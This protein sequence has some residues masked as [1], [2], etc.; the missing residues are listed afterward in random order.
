M[1]R[2]SAAMLMVALV[3][4]CGNQQASQTI[5]VKG[6]DTELN[7]VQSFAEHY[8][9]SHPSAMVSVL[10]GG[11]GTGIAALINGEVDIANS[12]RPMKDKEKEDARARGVE[13]TEFVVASDAIA[14]I[15]SN[16]NQVSDISGENLGKLFRGEVR[17]WKE[18]G[19]PD[20]PV[21]LYGRQSNSGTYVF[22]QEEAL[23]GDYSADMKQMNGNAQIVE[24]I[25]S[26]RAGIGYVGLGYVMKDGKFTTDVKVLK[27]D[28][29]LPGEDGYRLF[30]NLFQYVSGK[31]QGAVK[32]F[33]AYELSDEAQKIVEEV[34]FIPITSTPA[35]EKSRKVLE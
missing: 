2:M 30:R 26:D 16:D 20:A 22:F 7:L 5:K 24:G 8:M 6:S 14:I 32:D 12:S 3:A 34:G 31:P 1:K 29:K 9:E 13:P 17:N 19:G 18:I 15:V 33:L 10:G 21:S 4:G 23:G 25:K 27:L 35:M 11:S 28:G